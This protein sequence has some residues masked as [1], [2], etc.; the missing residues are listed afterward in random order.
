MQPRAFGASDLEVTPIGLGLAGLGR[1]GY[2]T[3]GHGDDLPDDR[4]VDGLR[5]HT[6]SVLDHATAAGVG[7]LDVARSYGYGESFLGGWLDAHPEVAA[8]VTVGSKWGYTYTADWQVDADT[9][10]VKDH[11]LATFRRQLARTRETL[12]DRLALYQVHSAT[13]DSG[14]LDDAEVL[15]ALTALRDDGVVVGL[16]LSGPGQADTL[17]RA[18]ELTRAGRA[19]FMAV[20]ATWNLLE[21]SV[22]PALQAVHDDGWGVIVKEAVANGRLTDRVAVP[23]RLR[24]AADDAGVGVDAIAIAAVLAQ[25]F[26]SVVLSG[27]VTTAHVDANLAALDLDLDADEVRRLAVVAEPAERYWATRSS[28]PWT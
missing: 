2:L 14:V 24:A 17:R 9:H 3:L 5:A 19:P 4:S 28:L 7:Y 10:E 8:G 21:P 27:A 6:W 26:V 1:P 22:G 16:T 23:P 15:A 20:Q 11:T 13:V 18:R 12:G 25:P